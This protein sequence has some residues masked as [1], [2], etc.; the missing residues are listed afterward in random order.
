MSSAPTFLN[1]CFLGQKHFEQEVVN[2]GTQYKK[3]AQ[4]VISLI[5]SLLKWPEVLYGWD[6]NLQGTLNA[7]ALNV[8]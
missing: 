7:A 2:P 8:P 4:Q 3:R 6:M 1:S 5:S